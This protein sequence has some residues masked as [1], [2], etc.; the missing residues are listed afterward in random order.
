MIVVLQKEPNGYHEETDVVKNQ[1]MLSD[2]GPFLLEKR[3]RVFAP[4]PERVEVVRSVV[5]IIVAEA[6]TLWVMSASYP[7]E[8]VS[9]RVTS[10]RILPL[11]LGRCVQIH[12][13]V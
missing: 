3:R 1:C 8:R 10:D 11:L 13:S 4:V 6:V 12:R 9:H 7:R 5:P 2:I